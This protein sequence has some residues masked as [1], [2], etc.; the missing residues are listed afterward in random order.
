MQIIEEQYGWAD[1]NF[2]K[3]P[4][5]RYIVL[6]HAAAKSC[7]AQDVHRWHRERGWKGIGYHFF[8]DKQGKIFR[9]RPIWSVG[10]HCYGHNYD[11]IGICCEGDYEEETKML[12]VQRKSI[13]ELIIELKKIYTNVS[14]VG[15]KDLCAIVCPGKFFPFKDIVNY[16]PVYEDIK[17]HWAEK[18]I[19][20]AIRDKIMIGYKDGSFRPDEKLSRA[21]AACLATNIIDYIMSVVPKML[22]KGGN[23]NV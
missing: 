13:A 17:G 6:H 16:K 19:E 15:H 18:Q 3:R 11:S 1:V 2:E 7:T 12:D 23:E 10:A 22:G 5:T 9:G 20:R 8:V 14:I 21:E 4:T